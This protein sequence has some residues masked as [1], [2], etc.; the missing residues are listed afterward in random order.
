MK[1]AITEAEA[2]MKECPQGSFT[3]ARAA[4]AMNCVEAMWKS[5]SKPKQR[6]FFGEANEVF[7]FLEEADRRCSDR[8][9]K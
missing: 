9:Q 1:L 2:L 3:H 8:P 6:E 4:I 7:V 5:L